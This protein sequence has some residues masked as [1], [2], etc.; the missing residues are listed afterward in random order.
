MADV[1]EV[2]FSMA[3]D[4]MP[5]YDGFLYEFYKAPWDS[6]GFDLHNVYLEDFY[7]NSL[8]NLINIGNIKFIPKSRD[9]L[10]ICNWNPIT[11]L[12]IL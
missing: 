3:D 1:K 6:A 8:G 12:N 4:K 5:G 9:P 2:A 7:S 11:L 10:D